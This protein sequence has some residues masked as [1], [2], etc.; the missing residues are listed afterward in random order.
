MVLTGAAAVRLS[1]IGWLRLKMPVSFVRLD[2]PA[3][4][5]VAETA[6]GNL[7]LGLEHPV[8]LRPSTRLGLLAAFVAPSAEHGSQVALL[9]NRVLALGSA[10]NGGKDST[11]LTPGVTGLRLG[12]GVEHS[13][14][15]FGFRASLDVPLLVRVSDATLPEATE[16]HPIGI[17]PAIELKASW[18]IT[19]WFGACA[20]QS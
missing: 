16:T 12:A 19:S 5:Q 17:L 3:R 15:P 20:D 10:L 14:P 6:L 18:W 9:N 13:L 4:A 2:F 1:S 8:Q 7:E 11:L